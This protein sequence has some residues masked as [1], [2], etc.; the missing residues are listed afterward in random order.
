MEQIM[1]G[2]VCLLAAVLILWLRWIARTPPKVPEIKALPAPKPL[3]TVRRVRAGNPA[4]MP[5]PRALPKAKIRSSAPVASVG[6]LPRGGYNEEARPIREDYPTRRNDDADFLVGALAGLVV[7]E[8][9][10]HHGESG[11]SCSRSDEPD[12]EPVKSGG[13]DFGGGGATSSWDDSSS[14]G[15][16]SDDSSN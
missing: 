5:M 4:P 15:S 16:S 9:M 2:I 7:N 14:S 6:R 11:R 8:I 13:G 1:W 10:H 12:F 3:P